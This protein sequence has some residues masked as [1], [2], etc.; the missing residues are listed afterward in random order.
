MGNINRNP[1]GLL[2][3]LLTQAGGRNPDFLLE[4]VRPVIDIEH[5]Y[6]SDRLR[7]TIDTGSLN[8]GQVDAI[9]VPTDE[10]WLLLNWALQLE[11]PTGAGNFANY[12][13]EIEGI[14]PLGLNAVNIAGFSHTNPNPINTIWVDQV[15]LPR[16]IVLRGGQ[17]LAIRIQDGVGG[18]FA[19]SNEVLAVL[20]QRDS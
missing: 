12:S 18:P 11:V 7:A 2:D 17:T 14:Q 20:L 3:F 1:I 5:Y 4:Q 15:P 9:S 8:T 19:F 16:P 13:A 6:Q 10:V